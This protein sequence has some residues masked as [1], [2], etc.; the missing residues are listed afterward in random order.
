MKRFASLLILILAATLLVGCAAETSSIPPGYRWASVM[1]SKLSEQAAGENLNFGIRIDQ[2]MVDVQTPVIIEAKGNVQSGT[3]A[4]TMVDKDGKVVWNSGR[5]GSGAFSF[6][7]RYVPLT[8][9]TYSL[10]ATWAANTTV[11]YDIVWRSVSLTPVVLLGGLGM[12]LVA[13]LFV[14]YS[15][16][17]RLGWGYIGLGALFW[18][19]TVVIKFVLAIPLNPV[20]YNAIFVPD[21]LFAPGSLL[22][23]LY[24][25]VLT[26]LT[27]VLLSWLLLR[28]TRLGKVGWGKAL[29]FGIGF[30]AFEALLLGSSNLT[31]ALIGMLAPQT[32]GAAI[33]GFVVLNN[34]LYGLA[35]IIE[36]IFTI[37]IHILS[38]VLLFYGVAKG[39]SRWLWVSFAYKVGIDAIAGFA[40][41]WGVVQLSHLWLI[42][43][44]VVLFGLAG[45][46]GIRRV[47]LHY[48]PQITSPVATPKGEPLVESLQD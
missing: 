46:W 45:I 32:L 16:S 37:F 25:G 15:A 38:N 23:D 35:P 40:Q 14:G 18:A 20:L 33:G 48:P 8:P 39:Q 4:F 10:G 5:F 26:G 12:I 30:G 9:G 1:G 3:L 34:P 28:Y 29:A 7:S 19:G 47:A 31:G 6:Q 21:Q 22:F 24:V 41:I 44:F 36:R 27:E 43:G 11:T 17:R 13:L 42:E 2:A